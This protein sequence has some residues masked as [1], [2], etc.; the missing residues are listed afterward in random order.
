MIRYRFSQND[1]RSGR[2]EQ[3]RFQL[4]IYFKFTTAVD[5]NECLK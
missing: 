3:N 4:K 1:T 5:V 2:S